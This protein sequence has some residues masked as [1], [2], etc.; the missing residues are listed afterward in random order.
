MGFSKDD[1]PEN[2]QENKLEEIVKISLE[3]VSLIDN[4]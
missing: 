1:I 3:F 2:I 4:E